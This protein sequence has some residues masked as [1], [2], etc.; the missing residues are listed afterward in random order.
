MILGVDGTVVDRS[1]RCGECS[2]GEGGGVGAFGVAGQGKISRCRRECVPLA[3]F[4]HRPWDGDAD[5]GARNLLGDLSE[6]YHTSDEGR[7]I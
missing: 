6:I 7:R 4:A 2:R 5:D 3:W 1:G